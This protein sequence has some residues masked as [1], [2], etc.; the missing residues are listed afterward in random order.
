LLARLAG[1]DP[2]DRVIDLGTGCGIIPLI[3]ARSGAGR[4]ILGIEIQDELADIARRNVLL[5]DLSDRITI[6]RYD[7]RHLCTLLPASSFDSVIANPPFRSVSSGRINPERQKSIARHELMLTLSDIVKASHHV[8]T[9]P[10]RLFMIYPARRMVDLLCELRAQ[11]IEPKSIRMIHGRQNQRAKLVF[12]EG[13]KEAGVEL[14]V[15]EPLI[16]YDETGNYTE[17]LQ[18]IY[19][20]F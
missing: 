6:E 3:L 12:V 19:S 5:N 1:I 18:K 17:T 13:V 9:T 7:V 11:H 14:E 15:Q 2:A 20:L 8:L 16:L 10:G 4:N